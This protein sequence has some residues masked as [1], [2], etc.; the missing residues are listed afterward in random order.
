MPN[1]RDENI[2]RPADEELIGTGDDLNDDE[3]FDEDD[4]VED[5]DEDA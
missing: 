3:D 4:E 5:E 2:G 1:D